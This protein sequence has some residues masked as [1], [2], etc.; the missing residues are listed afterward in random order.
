MIPSV[1]GAA[2]RSFVA[3][4]VAAHG[5][6]GIESALAA[7]GPGRHRFD[8]GRSDLGIS[9]IAWYPATSVHRMLD[10]LL[11]DADQAQRAAIIETGARHSVETTLDGWLG[12]VVRWLASPALCAATAP[13]L[14]QAFYNTG[15]VTIGT[16]GR[17]SHVMRVTGWEGHHPI[18][19]RMN[20]EAGRWI[21]RAVGCDRASTEH[22]ACVSRGDRHCEYVIRW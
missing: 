5:R 6:F 12:G 11:A 9:A 19:C 10:R 4:Y 21:Y 8:P 7:V 3:W 16:S 22:A 2:I 14:W 1:R 18:L 13:A 20:N 17:R 15:R